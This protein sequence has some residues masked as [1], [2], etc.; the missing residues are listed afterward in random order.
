[1]PELTAS[2]IG[3]RSSIVQEKRALPRAFL[4][5]INSLAL[6]GAVPAAGELT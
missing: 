2:F 3:Y 6:Y 1:M 4:F 5:T